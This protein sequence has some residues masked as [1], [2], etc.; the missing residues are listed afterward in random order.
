MKTYKSQTFQNVIL[1]VIIK[2]AGENH[3]GHA[4]GQA[5]KQLPEDRKKIERPVHLAFQQT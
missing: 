5:K 3:K 2:K 1:E 4:F